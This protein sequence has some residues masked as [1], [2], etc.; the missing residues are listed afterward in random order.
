[1]QDV[2]FNGTLIRI[3][4]SN[5]FPNGATL[6][7]F[8]DDTDPFDIPGIDIAEAVMELNGKLIWWSKAA[9]LVVNISATPNS[10]EDKI[11]SAI[12]E[13]NRVSLGKLS[14][15]DKITLVKV[16]PAGATSTLLDGVMTKGMPGTSA[17]S[18]GRLKTKVYSFTFRGISFG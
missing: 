7:M 6:N 13:A 16:D 5:S 2:S 9:P 11:L 4:A 14:A 18:N 17:S 12:F 10:D 15:R 8:S 3:K 1:M